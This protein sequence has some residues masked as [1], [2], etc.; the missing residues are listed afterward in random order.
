MT[1]IVTDSN[2]AVTSFIWKRAGST[3]SETANYT[4]PTVH[5]SH[6]GSYT[7]GAS[8]I[9]GSSKPSTAIQLEVLCK[10]NMHITIFKYFYDFIHIVGHI[11]TLHKL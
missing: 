1:C 11:H 3:I 6:A 8:N 9:V 10:S 4:I 7:C 5:R 2:P